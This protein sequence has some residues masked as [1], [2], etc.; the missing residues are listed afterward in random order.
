MFSPPLS[1]P[2]QQST[3]HDR[4]Y[5]AIHQTWQRMVQSTRH[6]REWLALHPRKQTNGG[7]EDELKV[8]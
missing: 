7:A 2:P 3:G 5:G 1:F 8:T 4:Q 6:D